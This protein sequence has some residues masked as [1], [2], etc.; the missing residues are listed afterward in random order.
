MLPAV[1]KKLRA[2][3]LRTS[4]IIVVGVIVALGLA[5]FLTSSHQLSAYDGDWNDLSE[6]RRSLDAAGYNTSSVISTPVLL[7]YSEGFYGYGKVLAIIGVERPY[8]AQEVDTIAD[9]VSAGGFLLLADDFGYGNGIAGRLG[10]SFY[11]RRLYSSSFDRN[12]AFVRLN[13]TV[14]GTIYK[15]LL[16]RPTAL[17]RVA[18]SQIKASTDP[19][20]DTWI[21][22]NGN[23]E[24]DI[25]ENSASQPVVALWTSKGSDGVALVVSDPGLFINDMWGRSDNAAFV[26]ALIRTWFPGATDIIF[27]ETRHKPDTVRE[28]AWRTGLA[29]G[30]L[31]LSN[32]YGKVALGAL[33]LLAVGVGIMALRPP[34]EWRH[35]DTLSE[36]SLHHLDR[37]AFRPEDRERLR[38]ALLEKARISL[39]L[40]PD[41]FDALG[42]EELRNVLWDER[43]FPL[44]EEPRKVRPDELEELTSLVRAWGRR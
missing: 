35:E 11:G 37:R 44:V 19:D 32:I 13:A 18:P 4:V 31:A 1:L 12:P 5:D 8:L 15:V 14:D 24:R 39:S 22:E 9:F 10:L 26:M 38:A 23:G 25:D 16:D 41:E 42:P 36:I 6:F 40:Y 20:A 43:L 29:M 27:D 7:N 17:E 3:K 33:S 28:G 21:D 30:V 2:S 34:A